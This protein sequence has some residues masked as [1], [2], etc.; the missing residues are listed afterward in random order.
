MRVY[1]DAGTQFVARLVP[2][3]AK[4]ILDVGCGCGDTAALIKGLNPGVWIEGITFNPAEAIA[5][6]K[7]LDRVHQFDIERTLPVNLTTDFDCLL[8]SH[9]VEHLRDP[10]SVVL[11]FL[12]FLGPGGTMV[13][14]VPNV[15]EW[16]TRLRLLR[17]EFAY[18]D[19]GILDRTHLKFFTFDSV[20][21]ELLSPEIRA[22]LTLVE[23]FEDGAVPLSPLRRLRLCRA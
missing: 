1:S 6:G 18:A 22:C 4:R 10:S 11:T 21:G 17:G 16:R 15:L 14:A 9:V 13:I 2:R 20:D 5:A 8:L 19:A 23:K 3:N 12:N 7:I